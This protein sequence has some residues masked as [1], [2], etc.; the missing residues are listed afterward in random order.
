MAQSNVT[1]LFA[2]GRIFEVIVGEL[3][4]MSS[5]FL[6]ALICSNPFMLFFPFNASV[7]LL[8]TLIITSAGVRVGCVMYF[9]LKYTVSD[10]LLLFVCFTYM[11]YHQ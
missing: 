4:K 2:C 1:C 8:S 7:R 9:V 10:T 5:S 6:S 11:T 3:L